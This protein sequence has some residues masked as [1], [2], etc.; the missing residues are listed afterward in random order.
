MLSVSSSKIF[1]L[2]TTQ[3]MLLAL[4]KVEF[5][6]HCNVG[7]MHF[8]KG[9]RQIAKTVSVDEHDLEAFRRLV[10]KVTAQFKIPRQ[11]PLMFLLSQQ[12]KQIEITT[13]I[14]LGKYMI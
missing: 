6:H 2:C 1:I 3:Q 14:R 10:D 4:S 12:H 9:K 8:M 13:N 5:H 11:T 7:N